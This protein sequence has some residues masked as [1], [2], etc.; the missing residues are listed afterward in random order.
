M[1]ARHDELD[2]SFWIERDDILIVNH[3]S[4]GAEGFFC[5]F[6]RADGGE[7]VV[8]IARAATRSRGARGSCARA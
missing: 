6:E 7:P 5:L 3:V 1:I 4:T 2:A 8:A